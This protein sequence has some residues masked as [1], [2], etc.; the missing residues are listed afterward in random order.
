MR[1]SGTNWATQEMFLTQKPDLRP[2]TTVVTH[3]RFLYFIANFT[4]G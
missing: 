3:C 1:K 2:F 4:V